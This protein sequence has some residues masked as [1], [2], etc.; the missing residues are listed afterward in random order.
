MKPESS[1]FDCGR[2]KIK[3]TSLSG[4]RFLGSEFRGGG[5]GKVKRKKD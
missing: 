3:I 2:E 1:Y 4:V 5:G